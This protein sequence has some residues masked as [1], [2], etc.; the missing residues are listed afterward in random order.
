M[1]FLESFMSVPCFRNTC[2]NARRIE[3]ITS[4]HIITSNNN[5]SFVVSLCCRATHPARLHNLMVPSEAVLD[6]HQLLEVVLRNKVW[7]H[8]TSARRKDATRRRPNCGIRPH[9]LF[10]DVVG[11]VGHLLHDA[12]GRC[13]DRR[14]LDHLCP[15]EVTPERKKKLTA[16]STSPLT[17][18]VLVIFRVF[19]KVLQII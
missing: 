14:A 2:S 1:T 12:E 6:V 3:S 11:V 15:F 19:W 17:L 7:Q 16:K 4:Y 10:H 18:S 13:V 5:L 8:G 9:P